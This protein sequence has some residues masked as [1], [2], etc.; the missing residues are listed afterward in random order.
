MGNIETMA[1]RAQ[2]SSEK[3]LD[4]SEPRYTPCSAPQSAEAK[5]VFHPIIDA[6]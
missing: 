4:P 3:S 1:L 2:K 6:A 5:R